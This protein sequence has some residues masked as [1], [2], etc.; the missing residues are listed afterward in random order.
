MDPKTG[1]IYKDPPEDFARA[2]KLVPIPEQE[3]PEV[4]KMNRHERRVWASKQRKKKP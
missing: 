1:H 3:L 4:H 2:R